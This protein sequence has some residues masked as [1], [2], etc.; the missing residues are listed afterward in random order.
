MTVLMTECD[1]LI[2]AYFAGTEKIPADD[3]ELLVADT[4]AIAR[5]YDLHITDSEPVDDPS[6]DVEAA[7]VAIHEL[8]NP[9][10]GFDPDPYEE[11]RVAADVPEFLAGLASRYKPQYHQFK[12]W[13]GSATRPYS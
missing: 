2:D 4:D 1:L 9:S 11:C 3:L 13:H 10:T 6:A 5:V 7:L 12:Y 8:S